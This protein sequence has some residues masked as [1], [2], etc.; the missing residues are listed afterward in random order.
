MSAWSPKTRA[1][2]SSACLSLCGSGGPARFF[3]G[4]RLK[5]ANSPLDRGDG[6][7]SAAASSSSRPVDRI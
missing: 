7:A 6:P 4:A 1:V 3:E 2:S 5:H